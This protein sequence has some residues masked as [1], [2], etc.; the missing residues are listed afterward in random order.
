MD[1][2]EGLEPPLAHPARASAAAT[3]EAAIG[4][5]FLLFIKIKSFKNWAQGAAK[6]GLG[7]G[8]DREFRRCAYVLLME[9]SPGEGLP[10]R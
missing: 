1:V 10:G 9:S 7:Q 6:F 3:A 2:P 8:C 5:N 4:R